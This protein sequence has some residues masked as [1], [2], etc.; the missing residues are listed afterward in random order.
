MTDE[1]SVERGVRFDDYACTHLERQVVNLG[2]SQ[3][4]SLESKTVN[5]PLPT[6]PSTRLPDANPQTSC[7]QNASGM[8]NHPGLGIRTPTFPALG[9][10][11]PF[12]K[13]L[14]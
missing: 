8:E 3:C 9:L 14:P 2:Q 11:L 6:P 12:G 1:P 5:A 10:C 4:V 7:S 13:H